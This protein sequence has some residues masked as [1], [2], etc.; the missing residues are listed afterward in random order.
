[1]AHDIVSTIPE[2]CRLRHPFIRDWS[3]R[4]QDG[5]TKASERAP[6]N[7]CEKPDGELPKE[8][9]TAARREQNLPAW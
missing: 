5:N 3:L 4:K 1:M 6:K 9:T 7:R 8:R 2:S